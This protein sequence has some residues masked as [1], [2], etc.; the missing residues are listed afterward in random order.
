[1]KKRRLFLLAVILLLLAGNLK[2]EQTQEVREFARGSWDGNVFTSEFAGLKFTM[3]HNWLAGS[4]EEIAALMGISLDFLSD[5]GMRFSERMIE[6]TT[7]Y[8]MMAQNPFN[9]DSVALMFE[10]LAAHIG[11][12]QITETLYLEILRGQLN[13]LGMGY[14]FSEI[15]ETVI[16]GKTFK[17]LEAALYDFGFSQFYH[18]R[19]IG[20][21][22]SIIVITI[23][24]G[25][26]DMILSFSGL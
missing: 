21:F 19:R 24:F 11:G 26:D 25:N 4:D 7:I 20:N 5:L 13:S 14:T 16:A 10:N 15:T 9:G 22:M 1:M 3:P 8:D 23:D 6:L 12:G 18:A 17:T 2:G